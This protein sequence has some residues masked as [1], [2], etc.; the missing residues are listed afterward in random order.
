MHLRFAQSRSAQT[1]NGVGPMIPR[2]AI[3]LLLVLGLLLVTLALTGPVTATPLA[4]PAKARPPLQPPP[5]R[6]P[7]AQRYP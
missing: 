5:R 7:L 6:P 3:G 2:R 4:H 1:D